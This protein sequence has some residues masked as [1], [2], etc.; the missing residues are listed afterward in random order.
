MSEP[1]TLKLARGRAERVGALLQHWPEQPPEG[2]PEEFFLDLEALV[3]EMLGVPELVR[4][5]WRSIVR[6]VGSGRVDDYDELGRSVFASIDLCLE[7]MRSTA[8]R[9][10]I[11]AA[12]FKRETPGREELLQ[13]FTAVGHLDAAAART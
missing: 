13:E 10:G 1:I 2:P 3:Q 12:A 11:A 6:A 7:S 4:R 8:A 5:S 9:A